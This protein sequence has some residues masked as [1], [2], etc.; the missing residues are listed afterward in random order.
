MQGS[1]L[2]HPQKVGAISHVHIG[3]WP[4]QEPPGERLA[5]DVERPAGRRISPKHPLM[6]GS[7]VQHPTNLVPVSHAYLSMLELR[8]ILLKNQ[9][10]RVT[11]NLRGDRR[12]LLASL[13]YS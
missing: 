4:P 9:R 1:S 5:S 3:V 8:I 11:K 13:P 6:H 10:L 2:Q 7:A 12:T